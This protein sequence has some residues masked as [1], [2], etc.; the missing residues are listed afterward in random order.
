MLVLDGNLDIQNINI[1][2]LC[3]RS[4]IVKGT[5]DTY[6]HLFGII[7]LYKV[8]NLLEML[9]KFPGGPNF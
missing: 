4:F 3:Q 6:Q 2:R 9:M 7:Y 5:L 8:R 1:F